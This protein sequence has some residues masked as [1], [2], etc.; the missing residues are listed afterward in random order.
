MGRVGALP[1]A[2][3]YV[4]TQ[5]RAPG[6]APSPTASGRGRPSAR[7]GGMSPRPQVTGPGLALTCR[8]RGPR[9]ALALALPLHAGS[10]LRGVGRRGSLP[11]SRVRATARVQPTRF[12]ACALRLRGHLHRG[13]LTA[14]APSSHWRPSCLPPPAAAGTCPRDVGSRR[15]R[16]RPAPSPPG[17]RAHRLGVRAGIRVLIAA[18]S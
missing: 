10:G 15:P 13:E 18:A 17:P 2:G 11:S 6:A 8:R 1:S 4:R 16:P 14:A 12:F 3:G 5:S 7:V 9:L